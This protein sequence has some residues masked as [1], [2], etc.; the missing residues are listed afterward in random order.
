MNDLKYQTPQ[1]VC[2]YMSSLLGLES[3]YVLEPTPGHGRLYTTLLQH[4]HRVV[5]PEDFFLLD[6]NDRYDAVV[7]NPPFAEKYTILDN[8]PEH[9]RK[10]GMKVGY[11]ML[12]DCMDKANEVIALM[13]WFTI[14]DS[15][16]R[17]RNLVDYGLQSITALPRKTFEY[18]RIQTCILHL[19]KGYT[20]VTEFKAFDRMYQSSPFINTQL[21]FNPNHEK[22]T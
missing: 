9:Y 19:K 21:N 6:K 17:L 8:A 13:P 7:M 4:G 18:V 2:N 16:V 5:A 10:N 22:I 20:G 1:D 11:M 3:K 12:F 15:D 14:S